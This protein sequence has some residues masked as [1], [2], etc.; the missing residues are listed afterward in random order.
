MFI[1]DLFVALSF[2]LF[3]V[4]VISLAFGTRGPWDSFLWFFV[5]VSL[6][7]WAGEYGSFLLDHVVWNRVVTHYSYGNL[8]L[9]VAHGG[10]SAHSPLAQG[11][12]RKN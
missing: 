11:G 8:R 3:I 2:G 12:A 9:T 4:W 10:Q 5:V 1:A 6:F 7:A